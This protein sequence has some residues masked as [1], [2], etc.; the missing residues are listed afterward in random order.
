[1]TPGLWTANWTRS[2][3]HRQLTVTVLAGKE[4]SRAFLI[5]LPNT[6]P[7]QGAVGGES[8]VWDGR[9]EMEPAP[10]GHLMAA[11]DPDQLPE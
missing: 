2:P 5:I 1:M 6:P 3:A 9:V 7:E 8:D 4:A 10:L 11:V